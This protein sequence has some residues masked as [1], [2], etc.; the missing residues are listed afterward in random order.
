MR[1]RSLGKATDELERRQ[2]KLVP[3]EPGQWWS[4][5]KE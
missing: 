3:G 5:T 4:Q 2:A 1:L